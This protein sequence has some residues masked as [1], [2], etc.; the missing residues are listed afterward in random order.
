MSNRKQ[1]K[2]I[3]KQI[4]LNEL[5]QIEMLK[6][7]DDCFCDEPAYDETNPIGETEKEYYQPYDYQK[8]RPFSLPIFRCEKCGKK[9][10]TVVVC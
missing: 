2:Q 3:N 7:P 6:Y 4:R 8:E 5:K 9:I 1:R 10:V